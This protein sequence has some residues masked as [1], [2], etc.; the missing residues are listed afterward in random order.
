V[1]S[2]HAQDRAS[3][4]GQVGQRIA[5][6][7]V[8]DFGKD[9]M[10]RGMWVLAPE[11]HSPVQR[12]HAR[13][14]L[15]PGE[16]KLAH[17]TQAHLHLG[18]EDVVARIA[19]LEGDALAPG[20]TMLAELLLERS[21]GALH[22]DRFILRD[23]S[24]QRSLG[25]GRVLDI[26]PPTR[27]KRAA[28]HLAYLHALETDDPRQALALALERHPA[29]LAL[30]R[31]A[32]NRNLNAT[33]AQALWQACG[34]VR[35]GEGE[36]AVGF[37]PAQWQALGERVLQASAAEHARAP[38]MVGVERDRLRRLT[39]AA[40]ARPVFDRL[41]AELLAD[42]RLQAQGSWL[43]LP[44]HR[45]ELSASDADLWRTLQ[46][47]LDAAPCNPP[48]VRDIANAS[49]VSEGRVRELL[50]RVARVGAVYPVAHDHYFSATAVS[51]LAAAVGD[52]AAR[53]GT[54]R[55]ADLRDAIGGGRK[56]A[57]H[58]LEF[59]DRVGYTRRVRDAHCLRQAAGER[60][61]LP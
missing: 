6:N 61:W 39:M 17:W 60:S 4:L 46:P 28:E 19:L 27:H 12:L 35:V 23:I 7:L 50:K 5:L 34:L 44:T 33:Q 24:A 58:I 56:V 59:F 57:I 15:L 41:V 20:E 2:L 18:T 9:D 10:A 38:D 1:R 45:A 22:G 51:A 16:A 8:G 53:A 29:G 48:R 55:A 30:A 49:G 11:L 3:E 36:Q 54:V 43:H 13:I 21:I 47:L 31:F 40:L 26:F 37:A 42:G 14:R 32:L 25:G 52:I